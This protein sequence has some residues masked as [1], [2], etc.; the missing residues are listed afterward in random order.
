MVVHGHDIRLTWH[1]T[2]AHLL[3]L[4]EDGLLVFRVQSE[5]RHGEAQGVR[6]GLVAGAGIVSMIRTEMPDPT[7]LDPTRPEARPHP[8]DEDP[9]D[10]DVSPFDSFAQPGSTHRYSQ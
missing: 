9:Y 1:R 2:P 7:R 8:H 6:G 5:V 10:I 4:L 3:E